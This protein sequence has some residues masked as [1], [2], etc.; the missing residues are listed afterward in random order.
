MQSQN[1]I[2]PS[3][4]KSCGR[5]FDLNYDLDENLEK[6]LGAVEVARVFLKK[7]FFCWE[8]RMLMR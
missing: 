3:Q 1:I 4:C 2:L 5:V 8:C 7:K 6:E